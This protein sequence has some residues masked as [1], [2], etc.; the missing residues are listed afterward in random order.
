[1]SNIQIQDV[2]QRVQYTATTSQTVFTVPFPFMANSDLVVYQNSSLLDIGAS[3]GEYG[4]SGAG[5]PSGGTVTLVTGATV[6]DIITI[7]GNQPIDRT[8]IYS[9][10]ISNLTGSDLNNDFNREIIMLKQLWTTQNLLQ[11]Q[12]KPYLEV[13]QDENVTVDRWL[14]ILGAE[15]V[16]V[17]NEADTE[18]IAA[19]FPAAGAASKIDTYVTITDETANEPNSFPLANIGS[20]VM[21]NRVGTSDIVVRELTGTSDQIDVADGTGVSGA[22]TFSISDNPVMPGTAG[23]GIPQGTTAQ[24]VTPT[25]GIGLRYNTT[26]EAVEYYD[27]TDWIQLDDADL[28]VY[29]LLAGGT[30][31]GDISMDGV[32]R[33]TDALDPI[34]AQDYATKNYVDGGGGGGGFL[35]LAGGTMAGDIDMD[36]NEINNLP[37]PTASGDAA[38]KAYVDGIAFNILPAAIYAATAN[39]AGYTYDNGASGV[40]AT[41]T[42]GG[43]GVLTVD[44]VATVLGDRLLIPNQTSGLEN[45]IYDVTTEGTAGVAAILTRSTDYNVAA[46][47]QAG[48]RIAVV[49]GDTLAGHDFMMTQ[50]AAI[51]VGT[52]AITWRDDTSQFGVISVTGTANEIDVDNTDP[53][54][55]IISLADEALSATGFEASILLMGG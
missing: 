19:D 1:M 42:A 46:Q 50:T 32:A 35:P 20:G 30:M 55:P 53:Q 2:D 37:L 36:N 29:L 17:K 38:S 8:S 43:V 49:L 41:L 54:N 21:V 10:T 22:P 48:D 16:W 26:I 11:L 14:P 3:A 6:D 4:V 5:S 15:Q 45:G 28:S 27:G 44:G 33:V 47:M 13:S 25:S 34:A 39:L 9:A 24:R 51:T 23:M 31:S 40:G 52:T 12:Y 18:I 7:L